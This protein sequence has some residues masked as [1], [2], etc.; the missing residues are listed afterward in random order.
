MPGVHGSVSALLGRRELPGGWEDVIHLGV[1]CT[2]RV[3]RVCEPLPLHCPLLVYA[4]ECISLK[5]E[6][7]PLMEKFP[8]TQHPQV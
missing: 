7:W 6:P 1:P 2:E 3:L 4:K 8:E 5:S